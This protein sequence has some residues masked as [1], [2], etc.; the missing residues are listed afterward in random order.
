VEP[1]VS[2]EQE[3][4]VESQKRGECGCTVTKFVGN[5]MPNLE[6]CIIHAFQQIGHLFLQVVSRMEEAHSA[7]MQA[8]QKKSPIV[9]PN[10][11]FGDRGGFNPT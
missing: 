2:E 5:D 9:K 3:P 6:P 1:K 8:Q 7:A 11:R 4:K 10:D